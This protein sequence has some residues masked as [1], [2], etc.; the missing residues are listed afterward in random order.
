VPQ[1]ARAPHRVNELYYFQRHNFS[2]LEMHHYQIAELFGR[3]Y[4][5]ELDLEITRVDS[6]IML[7]SAV[8]DTRKVMLDVV[9]RNRG[10]APAKYLTCVCNIAEGAY[11]VNPPQSWSSGSAQ[12]ECRYERP[13]L[14]SLYPSLSL[15]LGRLAFLQQLGDSSLY[16]DAMVIEFRLFAEDMQPVRLL[17]E[18]DP[19][20]HKVVDIQHT[21]H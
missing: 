5:P 20:N 1:S 12:L 13:D 7:S 16:D 19:I 6:S 11:R 21:D 4:A 15:E 14:H 2:T 8:G 9:L 3:R 17:A 18:I 10:R